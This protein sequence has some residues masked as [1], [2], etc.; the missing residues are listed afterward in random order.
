MHSCYRL[1]LLRCIVIWEICIRYSTYWEVYH[2]YTPSI[3]RIINI[4]TVNYNLVW[5]KLFFTSCKF[6]ASYYYSTTGVYDRYTHRLSN[7]ILRNDVMWYMLNHSFQFTNNLWC[8]GNLWIVC[9]PASGTRL[10]SVGVNVTVTFSHIRMSTAKWHTISL[11][12]RLSPENLGTRLAHRGISYAPAF[13]VSISHLGEVIASLQTH[14][15]L[16]P[17]L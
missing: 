6:C 9:Y 3:G 4:E 17:N 14:L 5:C 11:V 12:P 13:G 1:L 8:G 2:V 15:F 10:P 7:E 16:L